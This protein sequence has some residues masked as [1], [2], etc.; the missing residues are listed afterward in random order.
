MVTVSAKDIK[1]VQDWVNELKNKYNIMG[2]ISK[3]SIL[4]ILPQER[5]M[6]FKSLET[7]KMI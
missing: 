4:Y 7:S 5:E 6:Y 2:N 1:L 3:I